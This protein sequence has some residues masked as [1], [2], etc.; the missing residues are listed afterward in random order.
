M[1]KSVCILYCHC[2]NTELVPVAAKA[3]V[4]EA[5][6]E[7]GVEFE[8]VP[9]L[10]ELD[11]PDRRELD[12]AVLQMMGVSEK[13][14]RGRLLDQLYDHMRDFF[15]QVRQKE[16]KAIANKR[17]AKRGGRLRPDDIAAQ[18]LADIQQNEPE[19]L[20]SYDPHFVRRDRPYDTYELPEGG[21]A[22]PHDDMFTKNGVRFVKGRKTVKMLQGRSRAQA[23]LL[24]T[25]A[26]SGVRGLVCVPLEEDE[27]RRVQG[28]YETFLGSRE[29]R[30]WE[31]IEQ[32]TGDPDLQ[33][34]IHDAAMRL[35]R[36]P[37]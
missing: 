14:L 26:A 13:A 24:H 18:I 32:R 28:E 20:R 8:A 23:D 2:S 27:C 30:L 6:A 36:A 31:L 5:L 3:R 37:R 19:L 16:E 25:V 29:A 12:D 17:A 9:D 15:E 7:A 22:E 10:C 1:P 4:L 35:V 33:D 21:A 34:K 11:M